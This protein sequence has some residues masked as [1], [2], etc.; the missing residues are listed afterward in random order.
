MKMAGRQPSQML[1]EDP[2]MLGFKS[3]VFLY[4]YDE[5]VSS[6]NARVSRIKGI[7]YGYSSSR[8]PLLGADGLL[9]VLYRNRGS[10]QKKSPAFSFS[11]LFG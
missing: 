9:E 7:N 6:T 1:L 2:Q 3:I 8:M 11:L 5:L 10:G 4:I